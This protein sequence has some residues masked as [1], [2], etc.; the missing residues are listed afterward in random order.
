M[1]ISNN[2]WKAMRNSLSKYP[3]QYIPEL[4]GILN[5]LVETYSSI[6]TDNQSEFPMESADLEI[7]EHEVKIPSG[8]PDECIRPILHEL[9]SIHR[10][11]DFADITIEEDGDYKIVRY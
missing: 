7:P 6:D 9:I 1:K 8:Y 11:V 4:R 10:T 3:H 2:W 5:H